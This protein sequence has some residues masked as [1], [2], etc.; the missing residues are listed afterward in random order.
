MDIDSRAEYP[1]SILSNFAPHPFT[2]DSVWC[3]SMEGLLQSLKYDDLVIQV[4]IC[5]LA[6]I[7]AKRQGIKRDK[8]WKQ[9]QKLWWRGVAYDRS[10]DEYQQLLDRAFEALSQNPDFQR[11]LLATGSS[12]LTHSI[13]KS[14]KSDTCLTEQEFCVRLETIRAK[15]HKEI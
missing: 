14:D 15:L 2:F 10:S 11:A 8:D 6:G 9:E 13:G 3:A 4:E 1:A 12:V 7:A 5:K